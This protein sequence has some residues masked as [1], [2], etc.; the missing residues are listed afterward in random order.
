M[1]EAAAHSRRD[2]SLPTLNLLDPVGSI[3]SIK[4]FFGNLFGSLVQAGQNAITFV[5][6]SRKGLESLAKSVEESVETEVKAALNDTITKIKKAVSD[7]PVGTA[8]R[9]A[10][11]GEDAVGAAV[12]AGVK[13]VQ[14][15]IGCTTNQINAVL[16]PAFDLLSQ[17]KKGLSMGSDIYKEVTTECF[18]NGLSEVNGLNALP[19]LI[20]VA[21]KIG[22]IV[23]RVSGIVTAI[24]TDVQNLETSISNTRNAIVRCPRERKA[25]LVIQLGDIVTNSANCLLNATDA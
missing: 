23:T 2:I 10:K 24:T 5:E 7:S 4:E 13:T 14:D 11:C 12:A 19:A 9:A 3:K 17:G 25:D 8:L 22:S 16:T 6:D 20:C 1:W 21:G 15:V 18:P